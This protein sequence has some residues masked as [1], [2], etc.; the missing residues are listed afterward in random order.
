MAAQ[1][2]NSSLNTFKTRL[3]RCREDIEEVLAGNHNTY[4][5]LWTALEQMD[6]L[7]FQP[8]M[9]IL[10]PLY[11]TMSRYPQV[12]L[13]WTRGL[14][15][16]PK[17]SKLRGRTSMVK[18]LVTI[19]LDPADAHHTTFVG[20]MESFLHELAHAI[21]VRYAYACPCRAQTCRDVWEKLNGKTGH[22]YYWQSLSRVLWNL[23]AEVYG[24]ELDLGRVTAFV[25]DLEASGVVPT[26]EYVDQLFPGYL[27]F[28]VRWEARHWE[29]GRLLES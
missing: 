10:A 18:N 17:G 24:T 3:V 28:L 25:D 12:R 8:A 1:A 6:T 14:Y 29:L 5:A 16:G 9:H 4:E 15:T 7:T 2:Q 21:A 13:I 20:I 23:A 11:F 27:G 26:S 22:A 19:E